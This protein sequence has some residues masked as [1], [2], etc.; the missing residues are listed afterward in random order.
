MGWCQVRR[1][2]SP[3]PLCSFW[4][5]LAPVFLRVLEYYAGILFLT[6]NRIGDF[7]E[8]FSSRIHISLHYPQLTLNAT[9][10]IFQLNI[11]LI[12]ERLQRKKRLFDI[13]ESEILEY[14]KKYWTKHEKMRW[15]GRQIRNA[16]QT[17]LALAEFDAGGGDHEKIL[18][19]NAEIRLSVSHLETVARAYREFMWYLNKLYKTDQNRLAHKK[20]LRAPEL[21][22]NA[23][24]T[25]DEEI[26][27][28]ESDE[29]DAVEADLQFHNPGKQHQS[30]SKLTPAATSVASSQMGATNLAQAYPGGLAG[31]Y[32]SVMPQA[33]AGY[34]FFNPLMGSPRPAQQGFPLNQHQNAQ[35]MQNINPAL[36]QQFLQQQGQMQAAT[37]LPGASMQGQAGFMKDEGPRK[38]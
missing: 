5:I 18:D 35:M 12:R 24:D 19:P 8:A 6:T 3:T 36:Y 37:G 29:T 9:T 21:N 16:C 2:I 14:A 4:L 34:P 7:D 25:S 27:P 13:N 33:Q 20:G 32:P 10:E 11:R 15:N 26:G 1:R 28:G 31:N 30:P 23:I 22:G 17:A 38:Q